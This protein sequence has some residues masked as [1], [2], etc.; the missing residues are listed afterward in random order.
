[1]LPV[2]DDIPTDRPPVVTV[3]L[4]AAN[5]LVFSLFV[6]AGVL[7]VVANV[8]FLWLFGPSVE[9]AMGRGRFLAFFL[10]GGVVAAFAQAA[11]DPSATVV[12]AGASG[13]ISAV[14][15]GY[16]RL[17]PWAH[18]LTLVFFVLFFTIVE[19]PVAVMLVVWIALQGLFGAL[20]PGAGAYAAHLAGVAFGV[21]AVPLLATS[22]KTP[23]AL[24]RRGRAAYR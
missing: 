8:L 17:Y 3:A 6:H 20:D 11:A 14:V 18:I 12:L 9:D 22:V 21:L 5:V 23:A 4:I 16:L 24:L 15:G 7:H 1:V 2:K 19:I 10:A 13:A